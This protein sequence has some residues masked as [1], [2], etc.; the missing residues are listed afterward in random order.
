MSFDAE[1]TYYR[2]VRQGPDGNEI[3][4]TA[5]YELV[6]NVFDIYRKSC[7]EDTFSIFIDRVTVKSDLW[8]HYSPH[9]QVSGSREEILKKDGGKQ[10]SR[11]TEFYRHVRFQDPEWGKIDNHS[12]ITLRVL[13]DHKRNVVSFSYALCNGDLFERRIGREIA[14]ER[15]PI[16]EFHFKS[17]KDT[18]ANNSVTNQ[19]L[20]FI[21]NSTSGELRMLRDYIEKKLREG[22]VRAI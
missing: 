22:W 5:D 16:A 11:F 21:M 8:L 4:K 9:S 15:P 14:K 13:I 7:P 2:L 17:N 6:Q 1:G 12:G 18:I 3:L 19:I 20:T 10:K